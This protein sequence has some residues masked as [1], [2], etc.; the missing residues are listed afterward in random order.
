MHTNELYW[1]LF[2]ISAVLHGV[3]KEVCWS[4]PCDGLPSSSGSQCPELLG[5][6]KQMGTLSPKWVLWLKLD[7]S[8]AQQVRAGMRRAILH[9]EQIFIVLSFFNVFFS[10][11]SLSCYGSRG[12]LGLVIAPLWRVFGLESSPYGSLGVELYCEGWHVSYPA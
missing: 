11:L 1:K 4:K 9:Q 6:T 12:C 10:Y 5:E 8:D 2:C 3:S 7:R